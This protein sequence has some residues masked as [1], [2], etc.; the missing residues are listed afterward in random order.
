MKR[1]THLMYNESIA[2]KSTI[3]DVDLSCSALP[4]APRCVTRGAGVAVVGP[5]D[6]L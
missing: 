1:A 2:H 4:T 3:I 6:G 5:S